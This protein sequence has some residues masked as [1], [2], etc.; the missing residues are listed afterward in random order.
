MRAGKDWNKWDRIVKRRADDR[1]RKWKKIRV[2][3][4]HSRLNK[5]MTEEEEGEGGKL[6][7]RRAGKELVKWARIQKRDNEDIEAN[8]DEENE[9]LEENEEEYADEAG[10]GVIY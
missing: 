4:T 10:I 9:E 8:E 3:R 7:N 2:D 1:G 6:S 5:R